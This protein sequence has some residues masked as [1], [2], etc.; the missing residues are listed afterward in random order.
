MRLFYKLNT[1]ES[2]FG[3][4]DAAF[5][6]GEVDLVIGFGQGGLAFLTALDFLGDRQP[7][8]EW[9][10]IGLLGF[11]QEFLDVEVEFLE[12]LLGVTVADGGV[13]AGVGED[14]GAIDGEADL[15]DF[16]DSAAGDH[17]QNLGEGALREEAFFL[18]EGAGGVDG[19]DVDVDES[20]HVKLRF[21]N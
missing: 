3:F 1:R 11:C 19:L 4:H 5:F 14:F 8:L 7:V 2:V 10:G 6:L 15:A 21:R 18:P 16:E 12:F 17:F 20:W 13:F 9:G